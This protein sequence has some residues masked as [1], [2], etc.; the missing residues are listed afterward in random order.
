VAAGI[1]VVAGPCRLQFV[2]H[3]LEASPGSE[4]PRWEISLM[5][6]LTFACPQT[7]RVID[8]GVVTDSRTFSL[9]HGV[10]MR[11]QCPYCGM[12]HSFSIERGSLSPPSYWP[13]RRIRQPDRFESRRKDRVPKPLLRQGCG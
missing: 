11:V 3:S 8:A 4:L 6:S 9:V 12:R 10:I 1:L 5:Q 2:S 7:G 13:S